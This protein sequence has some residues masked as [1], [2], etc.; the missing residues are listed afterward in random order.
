LKIQHKDKDF[1]LV[2]ARLDNE[3]KGDKRKEVGGSNL[4]A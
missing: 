1:N 3:V 2:A 4:A